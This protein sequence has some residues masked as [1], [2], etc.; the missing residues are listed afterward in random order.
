MS[1]HAGHQPTDVGHRDHR[2]MAGRHTGDLVQWRSTST[3]PR[4]SRAEFATTEFVSGWHQGRVDL[5]STAGRNRVDLRL[6]PHRV[7]ASPC[8]PI[9]TRCRCRNSPVRPTPRRSPVCRTPAGTTRTP[10]CCSAP[11]WR[12]PRLRTLPVGVRLVFQPAEEVMPGG[13]LDVVAAGGMTGVSR[14]FALHCDPR[15]EVGK[16][17]VRAGAITSAADTVEL[18]L[19]SPGGHTSRPHLT[20]DLVYAIGT[21]ITGLPGLLSRRI[22]PRDQHDHGLGRGERGQGAQRDSADGHAHGHRAHRRS[23]HLAAAGTAG[24]RDRRRPARADGRALPAQLQARR[25]AGGQRADVGAD[26]RERDPGDRARTR[27]P[28]L[29]SRAA[30]RTSPGTWRKCPARWPGWASG[31]A[32]ASSWIC[33]NRRSTSTSARWRSAC[34]P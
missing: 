33:T 20:S 14:I 10:R 1:D 18:V 31:P 29:R 8:A 32:S 5:G 4:L 11:G 9:W 16:V 27:W 2:R 30:A 26:V 28:T 6:R 7:R 17:G 3:R 15:L 25:A 13:A 24:P 21:V 12:W 23:R 19:D 34:E 22:D